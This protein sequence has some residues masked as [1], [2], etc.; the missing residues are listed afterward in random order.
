MSSAAVARASWSTTCCRRGSRGC[1]RCAGT[2]GRRLGRRSLGEEDDGRLLWAE[3][4]VVGA[5]FVGTTGGAGPSP[6][7][8]VAVHSP[9]AVGLEVVPAAGGGGGGGAGGAGA[10]GAGGGGGG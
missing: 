5:G 6:A 3:A 1:S 9:A 8:A 7:G 2:G 4:V 10:P